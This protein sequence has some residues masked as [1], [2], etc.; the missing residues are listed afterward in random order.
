MGW[1]AYPFSDRIS[2]LLVGTP[3]GSVFPPR[4]PIPFTAESARTHALRAL[5]AYVNELTFYRAMGP[6][7]P[8]APFQIA[9]DRFLLEWPDSPEQE[10]FPRIVVMPGPMEVSPLGIGGLSPDEDTRDVFGPGTVVLPQHEHVERVTLQVHASTKSMRRAVAAGLEVAFSP[11][12]ERAGILFTLPEYFGQTARFTYAMRSHNDTEDNARKRRMM[13]VQL[14]L[15][16]NVVRLVRYASLDPR[17]EVSA[18]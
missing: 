18:S 5:R 11:T 3:W 7:V 15:Q 12:E 17:V 16:V 9:K 14:D 1:T 10:L 8:P 4:Q 6:G 13:D 2:R